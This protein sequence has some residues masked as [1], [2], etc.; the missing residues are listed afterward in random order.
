MELILYRHFEA[1]YLVN[2][3]LKDIT[4]VMLLICTA[5][6]QLGETGEL[7]CSIDTSPLSNRS[8]DREVAL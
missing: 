6:G 8:V 7:K 2:D 3:D 1:G 4:V 5:K